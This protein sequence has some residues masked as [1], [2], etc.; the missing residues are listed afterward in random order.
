MITLL[1]EYGSSPD[2]SNRIPE[3]IEFHQG[4]GQTKKKIESIL[5]EEEIHKL[6]LAYSISYQHNTHIWHK[7]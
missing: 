5:D 3:V 6:L 1:T 7:G 4:C 2:V